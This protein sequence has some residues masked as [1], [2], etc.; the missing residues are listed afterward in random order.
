MTGNDI[1]V[2]RT[3]IMET[4]DKIVNSPHVIKY[5]LT[6]SAFEKIFFDIRVA[7][8]EHLFLSL[9]CIAGVAFGIFSWL[10]GRNRRRG[11]HFRLD[12]SMSLPGFKEGLLGNNAGNEKAD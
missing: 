3:S 7:F 2:R 10:R 5:K 8:T 1:L 11:G 12:D 9:G 6:I 4:L